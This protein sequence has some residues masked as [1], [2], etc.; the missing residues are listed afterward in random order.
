MNSMKFSESEG[1]RLMRADELTIAS[2][3]HPVIV[4]GAA[5]Y[6]GYQF[7]KAVGKGARK[8]QDWVQEK[9]SSEE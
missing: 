3:G 6:G 1:L 7:G 8:L 9:R 5:I 2:G 4:A